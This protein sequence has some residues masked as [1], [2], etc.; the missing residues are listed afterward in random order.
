MEQ[1]YGY[2]GREHDL[3]TG[4]IYYRARHYDPATGQFI[5]RDPIGFAAGDLNLYAYTWSDPYNWADPSGLAA[6]ATANH[7]GQTGIRNAAIPPIARGI[8]SLANRIANILRQVRIPNSVADTGNSDSSASN[9]DDS[10]DDDGSDCNPETDP[11]CECYP[12]SKRNN[13]LA[14]SVHPETKVPFDSKG[15][16]IFEYAVEVTITV[17]GKRGVDARAA[18][19]AAGLSGTPDGYVWHH[20]QDGKRMQLVDEDT[21]RK[22]GHGGGVKNC[23]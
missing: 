13:K 6:E 4:L 17:T 22:T 9:T 21:H 19:K 18:N 15:Y 5:Q 8:A 3:E 11:N 12:D 7:A 2:T 10:S 1:R 23:K 20:H 16:P 14:N